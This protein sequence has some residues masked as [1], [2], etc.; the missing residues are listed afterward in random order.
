MGALVA[1]TLV[2]VAPTA[3]ADPVAVEEARGRAQQA[4]QAL[5]DA[6]TR[7]AELETE[8]A[9]LQRQ[10]E[11]AQ[12]AL[13]ALEESV[14]TAAVQRYIAGEAPDTVILS[15]SNLSVQVQAE[16][17]MRFLT[18]GDQDAIDQHRA[19]TEDLQHA[20]AQLDAALA[21]QRDTIEELRQRRAELEAEL[22]RLEELERQRQAEER[23]QAELARQ[24]AA[25][26]A[27]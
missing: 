21:E 22:A 10:T 25:E 17:L 13:G 27:A 19:I 3:V 23:R 12:A 24:R 4:A 2:T 26:E 20:T 18:L 11:Q 7:L 1:G 5:S 8:I 9:A 16:T 14:Q 6:E 15:G